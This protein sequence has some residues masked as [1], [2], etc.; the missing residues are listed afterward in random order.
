MANATSPL[1][2]HPP[3]PLDPV[4]VRAAWQ[5]ASRGMAT[6][7]ALLTQIGTALLDRLEEIRLAPEHILDLGDRTGQMAR[8]LQKR[9]PKARIVALTCAESLAQQ[10]RYRTPP[11]RHRPHPLV[12]ELTRL[13]LGKGRFDLVVS[14]MALHGTGHMT[15][16]LREIRRVLAPDRPL[17]LT[18]PGEQTLWELHACLTQWHQARNG[19]PW[20]YGPPLPSL[21]ALGDML[22]SSGFVLPVVDR[23]RITLPFP[24][25]PWLLRRLKAVGAGNH[26]HDRHPGLRGRR[27]LME[28]NQMYASRFGQ[29]DQPLTGTLDLLFGHAWKSR[30]NRGLRPHPSGPTEGDHPPGSPN[31]KNNDEFR[32]YGKVTE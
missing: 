13:P 26:R 1:T 21:S 27:Y 2:F 24:D 25:I 16:S 23:D 15:A 18:V 4:R 7:G 30:Q 17:L 28:L 11:W 31:V 9:W 20:E 32:C 6:H 10:G 22:L 29:A 5:R 19:P 14:N 8:Q 3:S 12:G